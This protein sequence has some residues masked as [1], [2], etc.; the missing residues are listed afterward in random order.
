[1]CNNSQQPLLLAPF[2]FS[3]CLPSLPL[4]ACVTSPAPR[5]SV[6]QIQ[7]LPLS[8]PAHS[9]CPANPHLLFL[10]LHLLLCWPLSLSLSIA[11][12]PS[13]RFTPLPPHFCLSLS[14]TH[15]FL[16]FSHSLPAFLLPPVFISAAAP[17]PAHLLLSLLQSTSS[18]L[19]QKA[20]RLLLSYSSPCHTCKLSPPLGSL[21]MSQSSPPLSRSSSV[22]FLH[23]GELTGAASTT[24]R[25]TRRLSVFLPLIP[26]R[27]AP[28]YANVLVTAH[29]IHLNPHILPK[30]KTRM[31]EGMHIAHHFSC[32]FLN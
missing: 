13:S 2:L 29:H 26:F 20:S 25:E 32:W 24:G 9:A 8:A 31:Q 27:R 4:R 17:L 5:S 1:M 6:S 16:S 12:V 7:N 15:S 18:S 19:T 28:C 10:L 30:L 11:C 3:R 22:L 21:L 14:P 23:V